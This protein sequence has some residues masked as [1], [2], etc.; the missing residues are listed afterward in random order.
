MNG[1]LTYDDPIGLIIEGHSGCG[2]TAL[3]RRLHSALDN[4]SSTH[5]IST[6]YLDCITLLRTCRSVGEPEAAV[7]KILAGEKSNI[8]QGC[9][10][11]FLD[12]LDAI[13]HS[14]V[15]PGTSVSVPAVSLTT[16]SALLKGLDTLRSVRSRTSVNRFRPFVIATVSAGCTDGDNRLPA[17]IL[18]P[19]RLGSPV[20]VPYPDQA[21][22]AVVAE[23]ALR[24][25]I[26]ADSS[27]EIWTSCR[28]DM[29]P[30]SQVYEEFIC[31][32]AIEV[33]RRTQGLSVIDILSSLTRA[34]PHT[35]SSN[36]SHDDKVI[37]DPSD[38]ILHISTNSPP[39]QSLGTSSLEFI[40]DFSIQPPPPLV[41]GFEKVV[42][43]IVNAA[44]QA[45]SPDS[46]LNA[47]CRRLGVSPCKGYLIHGPSGC[48]KTSIAY[49]AAY[50][51]RSHFKL[52]SVS[53][54]E[55]VHKVVGDSERRLAEIFSTARAMS[56]CFLLLDNIEVMLGMSVDKQTDFP[57]TPFDPSSAT[58]ITAPPV[59]RARRRD[60]HRTSHQAIDR[61]LSTLLV[62]LDGVSTPPKLVEG[63]VRRRSKGTGC[64]STE[65][66]VIVIATASCFPQQLDGALVRPGRLEEHIEVSLPDHDQRKAIL[67]GF[68]GDTGMHGSTE[69]IE[70]IVENIATCTV[71]RSP[72]E[73]RNIVQEASLSAIRKYTTENNTNC[74]AHDVQ[75]M[76]QCRNNI[77]L[78]LAQC[79]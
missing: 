30:L 42:Q 14:A 44:V 71:G 79:K 15:A 33:S 27:T 65:D 46:E 72:A 77:L 16:S 56:P 1:E 66:I 5:R 37:L 10:V 45:V 23:R 6:H 22:R 62:E 55:V 64:P 70:T 52:L 41:Y 68:V 8:Y 18:R 20:V 39:A 48:G 32:F 4:T 78:E 2:K 61:L 63:G 54:A 11:V 74:T 67:R 17:G 31:N 21:A 29:R 28:G 19:Y 38:V 36:S 75:S 50:E 35:L 57:D 49:R 24:A 58:G 25:A 13:V 40:R 34:V 43:D 7:L 53:C 47:L 3:L 73:L 12:N 76:T 26:P 9:H 51:A 60:G 69:E 59:R